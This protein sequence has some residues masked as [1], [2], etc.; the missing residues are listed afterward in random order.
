[1]EWV[2]IFNQESIGSIMGMKLKRKKS[3]SK[4]RGQKDKTFQ[5]PSEKGYPASDEYIDT[6]GTFDKTMSK[7]GE[8]ISGTASFG[9]ST[10]KYGDS[11]FAEIAYSSPATSFRGG[12]W[13]AGGRVFTPGKQSYTA[14]RTGRG[15]RSNPYTYSLEAIR[16][17]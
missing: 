2:E 5:S 8:N 7:R 13:D 9:R 17:V 15:D 10:S 6:R 14:Q 3:S 16:E 12:T 1:M 4:S 11:D